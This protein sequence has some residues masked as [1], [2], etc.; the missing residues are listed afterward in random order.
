MTLVGDQTEDLIRATVSPFNIWGVCRVL[1]PIFT[2]V[3]VVQYIFCPTVFHRICSCPHYCSS[4]IDT[5]DHLFLLC[6]GSA[7]SSRQGFLALGTS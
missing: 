4:H 2:V 3:N 6:A 7:E 5:R 1:P